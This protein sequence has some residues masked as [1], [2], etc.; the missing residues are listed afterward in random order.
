MDVAQNTEEISLIID[1][2]AFETILEQI[3]VSVIFA[4]V[5]ARI[6][7]LKPFHG[8]REIVEIRPNEQMHMII[9]KTPCED[10]QITFLLIAFKPF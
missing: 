9:H 7:E 5:I 4:V 8:R 3:P 6:A 10:G 2:F 1:R